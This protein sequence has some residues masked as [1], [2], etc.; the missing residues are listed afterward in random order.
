MKTLLLTGALALAL[1]TECFQVGAVVSEIKTT[2]KTENSRPKQHNQQQSLVDMIYQNLSKLQTISNE[3]AGPDYH[4]PNRA[5]NPLY[6]I[7]NQDPTLKIAPN[8][9][10]R[11]FATTNGKIQPYARIDPD[12]VIALQRIRDAVQ[13]PVRVTSC[14]RSLT[15]QRELIDQG[16]TK[17]E[18]SR[19]TS[20]DAADIEVA[21]YSPQAL[22]NLVENIL[23]EK[24]GLGIYKTHVHFDLRGKKERWIRH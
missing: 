17:E 15:R 14:Y 3:E 11:E 20:G 19:H 6:I 22:G 21:G 13:K 5:G 18:R 7:N 9:A 16:L 24:I 23:G 4:D 8:F 2:E 1:G 10:L 12:L